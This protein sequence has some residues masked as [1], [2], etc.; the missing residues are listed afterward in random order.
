MKQTGLANGFSEKN[1]VWQMGHFGP[2]NG[3]S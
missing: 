1:I 3:T 2:K